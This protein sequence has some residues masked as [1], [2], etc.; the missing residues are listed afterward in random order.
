ML[1]DNDIKAK[2]KI[3]SNKLNSGLFD[4]VIIETISLLKKRKHQVFY[5]IL[6][7]AYQS[8][9][10][11]ENSLKIMDEASKLNANNPYFLYNLATTLHKLERYNDA[12]MY[13]LRGLEIAPNYINILNNLAN[14]KKDL[15][16]TDDAIRYYK[17]SLSINENIIE[18]N[19][20]IA[21]CYQSLGKFEQ[22]EKHLSKVLQLNSDLTIADRLISS[23]KKYDNLNDT[24]L[25]NML[26]KLKNPKLNNEQLS[27]LYF[28]IGKAYE[29]I[30]EYK[31]SFEYYFKG[32]QI[33]K[34]INIFNIEK[35]RE[36]FDKIKNAFKIIHDKN[37]FCDRKL[38]FI[39]GMPRS[40][41]SLI[42]QILSSH[43]KI[44][45]GGELSFISS[46]LNEKIFNN[47][48]NL[49][50]S[51]LNKILEDIQK[52]YLEKI[53]AID[54]TNSVFTDK[55]PLNFRYIGFLKKIFPNS[56]I[57]HC[58]RN[59]AEVSWSNFKHYF[60]GSLP[61]TNNLID[62]KNFYK[63]Y[64]DM[65]KFWKSYFPEE[66]FEIEYEEFVNKPNTQIKE[67]IKFCELDWDENCLKHENNTRS[68]KTASATQ[69]RKPIYK[70]ATKSSANFSQYINEV[71][72]NTNT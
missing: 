42:E 21:N 29:D 31:S 28:A 45:G 53:S 40:G 33:L 16:H 24:H 8:K 48:E 37:N 30:K 58:K 63:L 68:I 60:P 1:S 15:N 17:K 55:A 26:D 43:N 41:T 65:M 4:E 62:I 6:S 12:E 57:V 70:S 25:T 34:K 61:F 47:F 50:T 51:K 7:V 67:L 66:I 59:S 13:F 5:N 64:E 72:A 9:G 3:L 39:V 22:A 18:T 38:I 14:L 54:K 11:F 27:N 71:L 56:K 2:F 49:K 44:F 46:L 36:Y 10:E 69:A 52:K 32:N 20:N 23:T 35:E 19:L